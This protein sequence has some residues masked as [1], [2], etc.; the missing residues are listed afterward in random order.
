MPNFPRAHL[1]SRL[2][3]RRMVLSQLAD[4]SVAHVEVFTDDAYS[5]PA[6][7]SVAIE[8]GPTLSAG[9]L[10]WGLLGLAAILAIASAAVASGLARFDGRADDATLASVGARR[11][12]RRSITFGKR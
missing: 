1:P 4:C 7:D 10:A 9:P 3:K 12:T 11:I 5:L 2:M 8:T 6:G